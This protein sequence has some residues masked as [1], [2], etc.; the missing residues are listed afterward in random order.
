[1]SSKTASGAQ[2]EHQVSVPLRDDLGPLDYKLTGGAVAGPAPGGP[3]PRAPGTTGLG[4]RDSA[5][6]VSFLGFRD[7]LVLVRGPAAGR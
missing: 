4:W 2:G 1:M 7:S 3:V 6:Q 5:G